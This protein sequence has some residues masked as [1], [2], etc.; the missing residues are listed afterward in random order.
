MCGD[1]LACPNCA[2]A[3]SMNV[4][5]RDCIDQRL[6]Y[7]A[8]TNDTLWSS[9]SGLSLAASH[10]VNHGCTC[11]RESFWQDCL[12]VI[13]LPSPF[14]SREIVAE[15]TSMMIA[16]PFILWYIRRILCCYDPCAASRVLIAHCIYSKK[17]MM[18]GYG[19]RS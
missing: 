19:R 2:T 8:M 9:A 6:Q 17:R 5:T 7:V 11:S 18:P 4:T 3:A 12:R 16:G 13:L 14:W 15:S 10:N 1:C